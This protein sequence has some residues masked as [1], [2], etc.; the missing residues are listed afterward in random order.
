MGAGWVTS[1]LRALPDFLVM[2]A[3]K[4]GTTS[5]FRYLSQHP[6][7]APPIIKEIRYFDHHSER[8]IGWYRAHFPTRSTVRR[9]GRRAGGAAITGEASPG[10]LS[11]PAAPERTARVVPD[12]KLIA[13]L[14]NPVDRAIS[15][16]NYTAKV[17][18]ETRPIEQAMADNLR[19]LDFDHPLSA[20]DDFESS[21]RFST[22]VSRGHYAEALARWYRWF[23][24]SQ[25][26]VLEADEV[27][28]GGG[29]GFERILEFLGLPHW[30]PPFFRE[31]NVGDYA[32]A[33]ASLRAELARHY[34][35]HNAAL[36]D[37]L[38]VEWHWDAG[39][40]P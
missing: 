19:M 23:D 22:Y 37:L 6:L 16:Y 9:T 30:R 1:P 40:S 28:R 12:A 17:R 36:W 21:L 18:R 31:H 24:R 38:G 2:G 29:A 11:H 5:V 35:P 33:P 26:L 14:R 34:E 15:A 13:L 10:Y 8:S 4:S 32:P 25:V 3:A 39:A 20:H 27:S 7:V